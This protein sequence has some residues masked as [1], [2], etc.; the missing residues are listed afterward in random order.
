MNFNLI[1]LK[2][3]RKKRIIQVP[4]G[5]VEK[6]QEEFKCSRTAVYNALAYRSESDTAKRIR[7]AAVRSY[8]GVSTSKLVF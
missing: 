8:G 5:A 7:E 3:A 2:M 6:M 4:L 1:K